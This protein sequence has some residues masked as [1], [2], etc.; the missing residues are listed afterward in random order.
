MF[1]P[2]PR[3][4]LHSRNIKLWGKVLTEKFSGCWDTLLFIQYKYVEFKSCTA[5][6]SVN[7]RSRYPAVSFQCKVLPIYKGKVNFL[8]L[9]REATSRPVSSPPAGQESCLIMMMEVGRK[10]DWVENT[11]T[12]HDI[13]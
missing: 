1:R 12:I 2:G 11:S 5:A 13:H 3:E 7:I 6:S 8:K 9:M 10:T 4:I